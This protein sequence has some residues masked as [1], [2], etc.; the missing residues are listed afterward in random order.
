MLSFNTVVPRAKLRDA[1]G[2]W[3]LKWKTTSS[4]L[5]MLSWEMSV[6]HVFGFKWRNQQRLLF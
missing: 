4:V 2:D 1:K 6:N 3:V 5:A